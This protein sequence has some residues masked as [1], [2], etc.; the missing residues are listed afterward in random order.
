VSL[1]ES[2][3]VALIPALGALLGGAVAALVAFGASA[4][5]Y[6]LEHRKLI[7][8][9]TKPE[10]IEKARIN[11]YR[12]LW[13]CLGDISTFNNQDHIVRNLPAVQKRLYD[14]YYDGAGGLFLTG[15]AEESNSTK[16]AFFAARELRSTNPSE[17]WQVFHDL[18]RSIRR[19]LGIF[20]S[21]ADEISR[22]NSVKKKLG[23]Y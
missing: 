8:S 6:R 5:S 21:E 1:P 9:W 19:D 13:R 14:W 12:E 11:I 23:A 16:A 10:E 3:V 15:A 20:E 17:I 7:S 2:L 22:V 4:R 18:R